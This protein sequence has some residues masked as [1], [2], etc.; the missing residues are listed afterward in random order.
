MGKGEQMMD[1]EEAHMVATQD[2]RELEVRDI[3]PQDGFPLVF[4]QWTPGN[5][6]DC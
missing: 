5:Q 1:S 6:R 2:G 3:G 4:Y